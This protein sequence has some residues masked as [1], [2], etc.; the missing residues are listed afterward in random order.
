MAL[1]PMPQLSAIIS[2]YTKYGNLSFRFHSK[3]LVPELR[4]K[5]TLNPG[6]P[7]FL[8]IRNI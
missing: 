5:L 4:D 3:S 8:E 1:M 6:A 7:G 2:D